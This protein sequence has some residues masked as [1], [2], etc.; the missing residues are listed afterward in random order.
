MTGGLGFIGSNFVRYA[1]DTHRDVE[2]VN[3]DAMKHGSNPDNLRDIEES[4]RYSFVKG[5][6]ADYELV[7]DLVREVDA[8]V[9]FAA[10]THVDRS[11]SSPHS[12][13]Q[14]N[15]VGV[16]TILEAVRKENPDARLV[17]IST[18]EVYGDILEGSFRE[19]DRLKPSSPYSASKAAADMFVL[20]YVRTYGI[21]A[22]I[23]RCTNNY[24]PYQFPEKLIPKTIIRA[25]KGL[26]VPVYG[27]GQNVRDWLYVEDH[28]RAI[29]LVMREGERGEVYN[30]SSGEER[31][32]IEVVRTILDILGKGEDQ[33]EFVEDRP[34]HD[35]RYSLDSSK[36]REELGWKPE[37]S[38]EEGIKRTVEWYLQNGWWWE[39]LADDRVLHPT[40]WRLEW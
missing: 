28:C 36:V 39:P 40:P 3:V 38:F 14:S 27:T 30:I 34:G 1:L 19:E 31:T 20:S 35:V 6:I 9:N 11:I 25:V 17:H 13:L 12:F 23:T 21:D 22:R 10:E 33:I 7:K 24:G 26:R 4:D 2:V 16:F 37:L 15:V 8:V 5:D 32:N 29:D 18:D